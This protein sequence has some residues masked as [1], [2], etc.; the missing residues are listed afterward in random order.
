MPAINDD[1]S[2]ISDAH[3]ATWDPALMS[4]CS[5]RSLHSTWWEE[6]NPDQLLRFHDGSVIS[7]I[8][9]LTLPQGDSSYFE[10]LYLLTLTFVRW[11]KTI[12]PVGWRLSGPKIPAVPHG[13][14]RWPGIPSGRSRPQPH[15]VELEAWTIILFGGSSVVHPVHAGYQSM[16]SSETIRVISRK[17]PH[18]AEKGEN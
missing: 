10:F 8:L 6:D 13:Q 17:T 9:I 5:V 15:A 11:A 1:A 12:T 18:R 3:G 14:P 2:T 4:C 16:F 7:S